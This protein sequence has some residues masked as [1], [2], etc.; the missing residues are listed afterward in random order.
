[1][2]NSSKKST[3]SAGEAPQRQIWHMPP[4]SDSQVHYMELDSLR[5]PTCGINRICAAYCNR[6]VRLIGYFG[7]GVSMP[8]EWSTGTSATLNR[9]LQAKW[10]HSDAIMMIG[11]FGI[12]GQY[13]L[14]AAR[15]PGED[16]LNAHV[17]CSTG[18][19]VAKADESK[20]V[21]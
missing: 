3:A 16:Y 6:T 4:Y 17:S 15:S 13:Y 8:R 10:Y 18:R 2:T 1:M 9:M 12:D 14:A 7:S 20:Y 11:D 5:E 19:C 21:T